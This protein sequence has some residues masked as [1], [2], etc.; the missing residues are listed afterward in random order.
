MK[1]LLVEIR[2]FGRKLSYTIEGLLVACLLGCAT[3]DVQLMLEYEGTEQLERPD[4][5]VIYDFVAPD[6][7]DTP[8]E[9]I[10]N[11]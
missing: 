10:R 11:R 9:T 3:S 5:V 7:Y 1:T 8:E 2:M 4:L 6:D